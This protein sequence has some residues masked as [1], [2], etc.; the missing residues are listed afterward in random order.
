MDGAGWSGII[1]VAP[2]LSARAALTVADSLWADFAAGAVGFDRILEG[3]RSLSR[4]PNSLAA[5][6]LGARLKHLADTA[7]TDDEIVGYRALMSEIYAPK[8][9][10]LGL[11]PSWGAHSH[12]SVRAQSLRQTLVPIVALEG[13]DSRIRAQLLAAAVAYLRGDRRALDPSFRGTALKVAVQE[14]GS[15]IIGELKDTLLRSTDPLLREQMVGAI[16]SADTSADA[17]A[18]LDIAWSPGI[19]TQESLRILMS[20]AG[21]RGARESVLQFVELNFQRIMET[22]PAFARPFLLPSLFENYCS[23]ADADRAEAFIRPKLVDLGG[24]QLELA[25]ARET[26]RLCASLRKAKGTE[27]DAALRAA[28]SQRDTL[29]LAPAE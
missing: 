1:A 15:L 27:I 14:R 23:T 8:L 29:A 28:V 21:E 5:T 4:N 11:D 2:E 3:A 9:A 16:G 26:I 10:A 12:E 24:G 22:L 18:A 17:R 13:R 7:L 20:L 6:A 19:Q 25:Q